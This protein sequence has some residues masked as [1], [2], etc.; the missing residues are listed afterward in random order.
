[1]FRACNSDGAVEVLWIIPSFPGPSIIMQSKH[2]LVV[3]ISFSEIRADVL[4][5]MFIVLSEERNLM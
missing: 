1:V 5:L 4:K 2:S 3:V